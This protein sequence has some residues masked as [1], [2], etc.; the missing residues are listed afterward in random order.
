MT[1]DWFESTGEDEEIPVY[2][3]DALEAQP[4]RSKT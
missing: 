3:A 1:E 2:E 4:W